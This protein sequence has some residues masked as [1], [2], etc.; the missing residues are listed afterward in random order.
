[1]FSN[2]RPQKEAAALSYGAVG[3]GSEA[4]VV[5]GCL[6]LEV[7]PDEELGSIVF[8]AAT[9]RFVLCLLLVVIGPEEVHAVALSE[10]RGER[11][12]GE[13][14]AID[15]T[16]VAEQDHSR[17]PFQRTRRA[18]VLGRRELEARPDAVIHVHGP[19]RRLRVGLAELRMLL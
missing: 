8:F 6:S 3:G 14:A 2:H 1:M 10:R 19:R 17:K 15:E 11:K 16:A 4:E 7:H 12:E 5:R 9:P 18:A 13:G